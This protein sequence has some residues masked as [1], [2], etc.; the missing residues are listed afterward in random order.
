MVNIL[1][2]SKK[3]L[4]MA[5][6]YKVSQAF[7]ATVSKED[8]TPKTVELNGSTFNA[9]KVKLEGQSDKGWVNV[10]KKPGNEIKSGDELYGDIVAVDGKFGRFWNFKSASRPMGELSS[11]PT[12]SANA[13]DVGELNDKIDYLIRISED[14]LEKMSAKKAVELD[15]LDI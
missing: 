13:I 11:S 5:Q 10:N 1:N 3:E 12:S 15:E 14:L 2:K 8:K 4:S 9:W 6:E 7:Q